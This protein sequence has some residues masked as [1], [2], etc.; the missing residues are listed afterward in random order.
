M[1]YL[2][3]NATA[4]VAAVKVICRHLAH[5]ERAV[6][7]AELRSALRP[8]PEQRTEDEQT[9]ATDALATSLRV[10]A[11][12]GAVRE[13]AGSTWSVDPVIAEGFKKAGNDD[14]AWFRAELLRRINRE[15]MKALS[16][17]AKVADLVLSITWMLQQD[18]LKPL[19][20]AF[21]NGAE[22]T[23]AKLA[24]ADGTAVKA[25]ENEEQWRSFLR[26]VHALGLAR[27]ADVGR[28]KVVVADAS[29]A[30]EDSL[31]QL[32]ESARAEDWLAQLRGQLPVFGA[33]ALLAELPVPRSGWYDIPPAVSLGLL[34]L[35]KRGVLKMESADDGRGVVTVGLG[36]SAR[37]VGIITVKEAVA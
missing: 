22:G 12:V 16:D 20:T 7:A 34:K 2:K 5:A 24:H 6:S 23:I 15:A 3:G 11:G 32:P 27:T 17:K 26:W 33:A 19:G 25:V 28:T 30:I 14:T 4:S 8:L 21:G 13:E 37:Q 36:G 18:P 10:A 29:T 35:E 9:K 31:G 1:E